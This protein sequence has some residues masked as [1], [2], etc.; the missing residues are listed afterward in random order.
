MNFRFAL[1]LCLTLGATTAT[2]Q[3]APTLAQNGLQARIDHLSQDAAVN[4][5]ELGML[6]ILRGVEQTLQSRYDYGLWQDNPMLPV[7]RL[8]A[9]LAPNPT[10][11]PSGPETLSEIMAQFVTDMENARATLATA[12]EAGIAP[13]TLALNDIWFDVNG[14]STRDR[15]ESAHQ[16]LGPVVLGRQGQRAIRRSFGDSP[17]LII[18]FDDADHAW[19][20]AYTHML[21]GFGNIFLAFDPAPILRDLG[22][23]RTALDNAPEIPNTFDQDALRAEIAALEAEE[24]EIDRRT[25]A[26]DD[27]LTELNT[28]RRA[29]SQ[30]RRQTT[31]A[32]ETARIEAR[33][34]E[35]QHEMDTLMR[36]RQDGFQALGLINNEIRSAQSKLDEGEV[37]RLQ[38]LART[39]MTS[40]D[41]VY[42]VLAALQQ[43]PDADRLRAA[44][45][46][47]L[48][49][50]AH[51]RTFWDRLAQETD[52]D[53]EW[54]PNVTQT[55][56]LGIEIPQRV[57]EGWQ[58]ILADAEALLEGRLLIPHPLL[59]LGHGIDVTA[60]IADPAPLDP[61]E[62]VHG[63]GAYPYTARGPRITA[64]SWQAFQRLTRGNAR[65]Y[66][67]F[68]N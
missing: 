68:L 20:T 26:V 38:R 3:T 27:R 65:G 60:Y 37:G 21:S 32:D 12:E 39:Q 19:L 52:D 57:A 58:A 6:Q 36:Q 48:A 42:V 25:N 45:A 49:M 64:Q 50:I 61:V 59:P 4:G 55:S 17:P 67:F 44:H 8:G 1:S 51:N 33:I 30:Q 18:R 35:I 24:A 66:A 22:M 14:N 62:W 28:E 53:R 29:L 13:F 15:D 16:I 10:P 7:L 41:A 63:K 5:F 9:A 56:A 46:D 2:A 40:I 47:W 23:A 43:Q 54:I 31:D 34:D 11:Q